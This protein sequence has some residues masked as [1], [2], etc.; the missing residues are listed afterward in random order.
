MN[1][2]IG[3]IITYFQLS[4]ESLECL[5]NTLDAFATED[6]YLVVASHSPIPV[7]LQSKCD[8]FIYQKLNIIDERK[9]SHGVAENYLIRLAFEHLR[10]QGIEWTFKTCYDVSVV[11]VNKFYEWIQDF[12]YQFVS[13]QWGDQILSTHSFFCNVNFFFTAFPFYKTIDEMFGVYNILENCWEISLRQKQLENC[14]YTY[15]SKEA[16]FSPNKMDIKFYNY[17]DIEI[18]YKKEENRFYIVVASSKKGRVGVFDYYSDTCIFKENDFNLVPGVSFFIEPS[19]FIDISKIKNGYYFEFK[20]EGGNTT[21]RKNYQIKDFALK[22]KFHKKLESFK[23]NN[24]AFNDFNDFEEYDIYKGLGIIDELQNNTKVYVDIGAN[25]G[26]SS[27]FFL[28]DRK[29]KIYLLDADP[30]CV[31]TL[32]KNFK[33]W[34]NIK[35]L[36]YAIYKE[37]GTIDFYHDTVISTISSINPPDGDGGNPKEKVSVMSITPDTLFE[38]EIKEDVI[39]FLK[40]DIEGEEYEF[41]DLL[42]DKNIS[43]IKHMVIEFHENHHFELAKIIEKLA[44]NDFDYKY[45]DW[46]FF[47]E[48]YSL[49]NK[50][51]IIYAK[52]IRC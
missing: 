38:R 18:S 32:K 40:I 50:M 46:K 4:D 45:F 17:S 21:I 29:R 39:D 16:F 1:K 25:N 44:R 15:P 52:K 33:H 48:K 3:F 9:Y 27:L 11:D 51:G 19:S 30:H 26:F 20:P 13:C 28:N 5:K 36:P 14:I 2:K 10:F 42:S 8:Y 7:E 49:D 23:Y 43:R 41:F 31:E 35:I 22:Y 24:I 47:N 12:N 34:G 37:N 6:F